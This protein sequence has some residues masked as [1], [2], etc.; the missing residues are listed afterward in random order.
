MGNI[1]QTKYSGNTYWSNRVTHHQ[2]LPGATFATAIE[3]DFGI[4]EESPG[5]RV[6]ASHP[7]WI[8]WTVT[9][10]S[11]TLDI[12]LFGPGLSE[13]DGSEETDLTIYDENGDEIPGSVNFYNGDGWLFSTEYWGFYTGTSFDNGITYYAKI[14]PPLSGQFAIVVNID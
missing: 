14:I 1:R 12:T 4:P 2:S 7:V 9:G 11:G 5:Y 8:K 6:A 3:I 13:V 10:G